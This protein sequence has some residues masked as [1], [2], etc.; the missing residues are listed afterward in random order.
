M[1]PARSADGSTM[2]AA[3]RHPDRTML[4]SRRTRRALSTVFVLLAVASAVIVVVRARRARPRVERRPVHAPISPVGL[5]PWTVVDF[6]PETHQ[7][8]GAM[9][10]RP[11]PTQPRTH[12]VAT[13][14]GAVLEVRRSDAGLETRTLVDLSDVP[15]I[16][17]YS[18]ALHPD[19][20]RNG[21]LFVF[22]R[23]GADRELRMRLAELTVPASGTATARDQRPLLTQPIAIVDHLGGALEFDEQGMLLFTVGDNGNSDDRSRAQRVDDGLFSGV[24]R[25]DVDRR[26]APISHP[27]RTAPSGVERGDYFVPDDNPFVGRPDTHEEFWALGLR[28]PFRASFDAPTRRLWIG[29]VGQWRVEQIEVAARGTNHEWSFREGSLPFTTSWLHGTAPDPLLGIRTPPFFEYRHRDQNYCVIGGM[30][31]R[32]DR[33][34][35]LRGTYLFGDNQSGRVWA[36]DAATPGPRTLLLQLPPGKR[37]ASLTSI[38]TDPEGNVLFT[39]YAAGGEGASVYALARG[40]PAPLPRRLSALGVFA[41]LGT[42]TVA[43][44]F[45]PYDVNVPLW[46][47]GLA[48]RRWIRLPP[49]T[50]IDDRDS[51]AWRLPP[52]TM[53]VKHFETTAGRRVETRVLVVKD[54]GD[55]YGASYRWNDAGTDA[56]LVRHRRRVRVPR[57][58]GAGT[59]HDGDDAV[60]H[61][62]PSFRDCL[63]CHTRTN[64]VLGV[65]VRQLNRR[66]PDAGGDGEQLA[67]WSRAGLLERPYDAATIAALPAL[68]PFERTAAP[69]ADRV[70]SYLD[71]NCGFCHFPGGLPRPSF[72]LRRATPLADAH[73]DVAAH[74]PEPIDGRVRPF[75]VKPGAPDESALY[76]RMATHAPEYAMPYLGRTAV[77]ERAL[78]AVREWIMAQAAR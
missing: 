20:A 10:I 46:S 68:V 2:R 32:G 34:P 76:V 70:R 40:T 25:I 56:E 28:N 9:Q 71:A 43:D 50:T 24:L 21:R 63:V 11:H 59:R 4:R 36:V 47:D 53:L 74:A 39:N 5:A 62:L 14:R 38:A 61:R 55:V 7:L 72:D 42:L 26:G 67:A 69:L 52:G 57:A 78:A 18:F 60:A 31:Y 51:D 41:D 1:A 77:D 19:Y 6:Y 44:G 17:L 48:K 16:W 64:P 33:F 75:V 58:A 49:G 37:N 22:Y 45:R 66:V 30:V 3:T 35:E 12:L 23:F 8:W 15:G 29:E 65:N 27:P 73:L 13:F 54:D